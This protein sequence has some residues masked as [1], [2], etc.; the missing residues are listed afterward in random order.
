[1]LPDV[2]LF[3]EVGWAPLSQGW[4]GWMVPKE[5]PIAQREKM[6]QAL[7][8]VMGKEEVQVQLRRTG[9]VVE[10]MS[11]QAA[12]K[13]IQSYVQT[14]SGIDELFDQKD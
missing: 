12:K 3:T 13:H 9:H 2:P 4:M 5:T 7:Y 14:W 1:M 8:R 11:P 6:A 10:Q